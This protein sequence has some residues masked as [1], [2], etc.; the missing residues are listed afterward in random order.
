[1]AAIIPNLRHGHTVS[2]VGT[3]TSPMGV[4]LR[5]EIGSTR[6][7]HSCKEDRETQPAS[8]AKIWFDGSQCDWHFP[9]WF[10]TRLDMDSKIF[11]SCSCRS[12]YFD[13]APPISRNGT[14]ESFQNLAAP[15]NAYHGH[16]DQTPSLSS[17]TSPFSSWHG[18]ARPLSTTTFGCDR[19]IEFDVIWCMDLELGLSMAKSFC[20]RHVTCSRST[21]VTN[22]QIHRLS[23]GNIR[24]TR[25]QNWSDGWP[26][27]QWGLCLQHVVLHHA[28]NVHNHK[29]YCNGCERLPSLR[30]TSLPSHNPFP[31]ISY[32]LGETKKE[33]RNFKTVKVWS[34]TERPKSN[35]SNVA[36]QRLILPPVAEQFPIIDAI[37]FCQTAPHGENRAKG[38]PRLQRFLATTSLETH[39]FDALPVWPTWVQEVVTSSKLLVTIVIQSEMTYSLKWL[40]YIYIYIHDISSISKYLS[41]WFNFMI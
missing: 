12:C 8:P 6:L 7:A 9:R 30:S 32:H 24:R 21:N 38:K 27:M 35:L 4:V 26:S 20:N 16:R 23:K 19:L 14:N 36:A 41:I 22:K 15:P 10:S 13:L 39:G 1:M 40:L 25:G 31:S 2:V 34:C 17:D 11:T 29:S 18:T 37:D 3:V 5:Y 28:Y 33:N